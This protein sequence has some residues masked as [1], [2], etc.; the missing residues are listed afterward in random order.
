MVMPRSRSMSIES[1]IW[2]WNSRSLTAPQRISR[3]SASVLLPWSIWAMIEKLR[4][5]DRSVISYSLWSAR[6]PSLRSCHGGGARECPRVRTRHSNHAMYAPVA[7]ATCATILA[8]DRL[9]LGIGE[10]A[11]DRL[12]GDGERE[13]LLAVGHALAGI[14]VEHAHARRSAPCRRCARRAPASRPRPRH[15]RGRRSRARAAG[16]PTAR[17]SAAPWSPWPWAAAARRGRPRRR[18]PGP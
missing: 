11:L 3:R 17:A 16:R 10:R 9:D 15:R 8:R 18:P 14:D 5:N 6:V 12:Q 7:L 1:S 13:R 2:S 4:I